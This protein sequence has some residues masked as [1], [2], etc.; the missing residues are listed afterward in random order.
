MITVLVSNSRQSHHSHRKILE[1]WSDCMFHWFWTYSFHFD[2]FEL[3]QDFLGF[4]TLLLDFFALKVK[5]LPIAFPV[6]SISTEKLP[7]Y[8][9]S[10][11]VPLQLYNRFVSLRVV[12]ETIGIVVHNRPEQVLSWDDFAIKNSHDVVRIINYFIFRSN[13]FEKY[14]WPFL[15][16]SVEC[17]E[18]IS[19]R[20]LVLMQETHWVHGLMLNGSCACWVL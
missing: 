14:I 13:L 17:D 9:F 18:L 10:I 5:A 16:V 2:I 11:S 19:V 12:S 7:A 15:C 8:K 3:D 4:T 20:P 6:F 1:K